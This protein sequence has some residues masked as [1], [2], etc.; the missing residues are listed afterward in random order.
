MVETEIVIGYPDGT[1]RPHQGLTRA[2]SAAVIDRIITPSARVAIN[3]EA[4]KATAP[5]S[6]PDGENGRREG[7]DS[8]NGEVVTLF[9]L[10]LDRC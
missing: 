5:P 7:L 6:F 4:M 2:E 8:D 9:P 10:A 1:F 3:I